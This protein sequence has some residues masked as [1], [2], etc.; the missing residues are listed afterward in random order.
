MC[1]VMMIF[2]DLQEETLLIEENKEEVFKRNRKLLETISMASA[3]WW[4]VLGLLLILTSYGDIQLTRLYLIGGFV[5]LVLYFIT[6]K[7]NTYKKVMV[8]Y[9]LEGTLLFLFSL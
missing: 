6:R 2:K 9:Y 8:F 1:Y 7:L 5:C 3:L 4:V